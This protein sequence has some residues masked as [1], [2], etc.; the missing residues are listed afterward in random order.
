MATI[1]VSC[2]DAQNVIIQFNPVNA[3]QGVAALSNIQV[4]DPSGQA[5]ITADATGLVF[6]V[7]IPPVT[8][9]T[10]LVLSISC[11]STASDGSQLS[12]VVQITATQSP[13]AI[14][15]GIIASVVSK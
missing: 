7:V 2:T 9:T 6:T 14:S 15:Q 8:T 11:T 10:P 12:D 1:Q 3:D 5:T 13:V 4:V